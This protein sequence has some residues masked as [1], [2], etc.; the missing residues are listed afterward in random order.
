[1]ATVVAKDDVGSRSVSINENTWAAPAPHGDTRN[2][3]L[4]ACCTY[5]VGCPV[6]A[7]TDSTVGSVGKEAVADPTCNIIEVDGTTLIW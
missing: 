7:Y 5:E 4:T 6:A 1:M 3:L 2:T